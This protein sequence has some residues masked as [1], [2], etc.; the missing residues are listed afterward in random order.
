M[1]NLI[2]LYNLIKSELDEVE[3]ELK[4]EIE[5][6]NAKISPVISHIL[7]PGGKRVRPAILILCAKLGEF[8]RERSVKLAVAIELIHTATLVHDDVVDEANLRRGKPSINAKWDNKFAV[9]LGDYLYTKG[10]RLL[11][12][13]KDIE[14]IRLVIGA[15]NDMTEGEVLQEAAKNDPE[16][17]FED[18]LYIIRAKTA[19]LISACAKAG[20][21]CG[22]LSRD[23]IYALERFGLNLGIAFQIIDDTLDWNAKKEKLGKPVTNDLREGG[24]TLPLIYLLQ[25]SKP[26]DKDTLCKM[27]DSEGLNENDILYIR[28]KMN[29][30]KILEKVIDMGGKYIQS[31]KK[32]LEIFPPS[33]IKQALV[34][35]TD[36]IIERD[37]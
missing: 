6:D 8:D 27:L 4:K 19:G 31:A 35:L 32:E 10:C 16:V 23:K 17:S 11:L 25:E 20:G 28:G 2:F 34:T 9:L 22:G 15:T 37:W 13:D 12:K 33:K 36:Y 24:Y 29:D 30:Y 7:L 21:M 14:A 26:D 5:A 3:V 18:Y 1:F